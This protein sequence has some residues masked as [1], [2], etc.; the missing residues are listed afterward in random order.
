MRGPW[1][2]SRYAYSGA[3]RTRNRVPAGAS[4]SA[5]KSPRAHA[6]PGRT[7]SVFSVSTPFTSSASSSSSSSSADAP[8]V[9]PRN[10]RT[11]TPSPP[12]TPFLVLKNGGNDSARAL[13]RAKEAAS[14][15]DAS[16]AR[17]FASSVAC[18][19]SSSLSA[20]AGTARATTW[21]TTSSSASPRSVAVGGA[22][23]DCVVHL[24]TRS[25]A[26][27][28]SRASDAAASSFGAFQSSG[29]GAGSRGA[30]ARTDAT[31]RASSAESGPGARPAPRAIPR[32]WTPVSRAAG[33][34]RSDEG[35]GRE[36]LI[37]RWKF[38]ARF[39]RTRNN[40]TRVAV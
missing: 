2:G 17:S 31:H 24:R 11:G 15:S 10:A 18:A 36:D 5:N 4:A 12:A 3:T 22:S 8:V 26:R 9:S 25:P 1:C 34:A 6:S 20:E 32:G 14:E 33:R 35:N 13:A 40:A 21:N 39:L 23:G 27:C 16:E 37:T 30:R 29:D 38:A 7:L 19:S 28:S